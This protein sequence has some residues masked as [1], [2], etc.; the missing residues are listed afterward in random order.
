M[1]DIELVLN[2]IA[3]ATTTE[4]SKTV[5]RWAGSLAGFV[6]PGLAAEVVQDF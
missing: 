1:S 3:E 4:I 2:M 6:E 5:Q